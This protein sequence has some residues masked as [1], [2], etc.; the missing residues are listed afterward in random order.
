MAARV[1]LKGLKGPFLVLLLAFGIAAWQQTL[2]RHNELAASVEVC[3]VLI[4]LHLLTFHAASGYQTD[5]IIIF[6]C[7]HYRR[8]H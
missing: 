6:P 3:I 1:T 7:R 8:R 2:W 4:L 5:F